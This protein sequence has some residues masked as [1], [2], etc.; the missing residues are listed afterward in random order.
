M[1]RLLLIG[2]V[3]AVVFTVI[4]IIDCAVQPATRHR[5]APKAAWVVITCVPVIGGILWWIIGRSRGSAETFTVPDAPDDDPTFLREA[6]AK[7]S[8]E[9]IRQL[10]EELRQLDEEEDD[11]G[12]A[13]G[14]DDGED[15]D[16]PKG[17]GDD[18]DESG[19]AD[20]RG[21]GDGPNGRPDA[22]G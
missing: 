20:S 14:E 15:D 6:A 13:D 21:A 5:G 4:S 16:S 3:A 1:A 22:R 8:D 10:E 2:A 11:E 7:E 9:R 17:R 19:D 12:E 18:S